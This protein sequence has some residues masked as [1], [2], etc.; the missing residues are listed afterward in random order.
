[1]VIVRYQLIRKVL[2]TAFKLKE[3]LCPILIADNGRICQSL[4]G[5]SLS[6]SD[7]KSF[8]ISNVFLIPEKKL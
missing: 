7:M 3:K 2:S 4:S 6:H 1:M 8:F 5:V